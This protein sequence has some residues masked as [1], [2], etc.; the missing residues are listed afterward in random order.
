MRAAETKDTKETKDTEGTRRA[1]TLPAFVS[2]VLSFVSLSL[3]RDS[4][5]LPRVQRFKEPARRFEVELRILR[6][7][8]EEETVAAGQREARQV[9]DRVIRHRQPVQREHAEHARQRRR[10]DGALEGD[11]DERRP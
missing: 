9:E 5:H 10:E 6:L 2:S 11:R 7:D 1:G 3:I 4:G 8:A